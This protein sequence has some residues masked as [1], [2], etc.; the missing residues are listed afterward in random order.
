MS[1]GRNERTNTRAACRSDSLASPEAQ[2]VSTYKFWHI[3][4]ANCCAPYKTSR[5]QQP[6]RAVFGS[7]IS[8]A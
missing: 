8:I 7:P 4:T 6:M 5:G 3:A 2:G 1:E